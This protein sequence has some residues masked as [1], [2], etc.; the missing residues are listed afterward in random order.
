MKLKL[1]LAVFPLVLAPALASAQCSRGQ[2]SQSALKCLEGQDWD[3]NTQTCIP[4][5]SS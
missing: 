3:P 1:A 2:H 4:K 5:T